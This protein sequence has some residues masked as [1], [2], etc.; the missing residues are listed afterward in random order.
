MTRF[1]FLG[2]QL[3]TSQV[4]DPYS[5]LRYTLPARHKARPYRG[6]LYLRTEDEVW[7]E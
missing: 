7:P 6:S 3:N 4:S 2:L 1:S 5:G